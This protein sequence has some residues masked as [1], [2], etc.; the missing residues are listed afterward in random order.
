MPHLPVSIRSRLTLAVRHALFAGLL[1]GGPLL[2]A[3]PLT[4]ATASEQVR[5]YVIPAGPLDQALNLFASQAGILLSADARLTIGKRSPGLNGDYAV[6]EGL[7]NLLAGTGLR[8]HSTGGDYVL[9]VAMDG[10]DALELQSTTVR[11]VQLT[12][13]T[14]GTGSY[15]TGETSTATK[16]NLSLRE[17]PQ[18]ISVM[19]RQRIEDE[20]LT[21]IETLLDRTPGISVQNI[22][23]GRYD[24]SSRGYSID[25]FQ[26][27]GIPT[28]LDVVSQN[29]PQL[30]A[31]MVI[32]DRVEVLRGATGL[33]TGAGEPSGTINLIRKKPTHE[34]KGH[35]AAGVGNW[36]RYRTEFD[37]SGALIETGNLRGRFVGAYEEGGTH[38]DHY[39]QK[40]TVLY[41][42]LEADLSDQTRLTLGLDY[43]NTDPRGTSGSG[44]PLFYSNGE[45]TKFAPSKNAAARWSRNETDVYNTF[46]TLEH[47][48]ADDWALT[49][50]ANHM[51]GK[52]DFSGADASWGF[53]DKATGEGVMLYGGAGQARQK[54]TGAD[55]QIQGAFEMLGRRHDLVVGANWSEYENQHGPNNDD[56]EGRSINIYTWDN[57]TAATSAAE[58]LMDYDGWQKQYGSY[59]ALRLKPLDD[60]AVIIGAR[61]SNYKYQL[62]QIYSVPAF[63]QNNSITNMQ[64]S[65]VVTPYAGIVYDIN[66]THSVYASYTSIFKPQSERDRTGA[67]LAPREGENYEVGLKSEFFSGRLNSAIALYQ[68]RQDNLAEAEPGQTVPGTSPLQAAYRAVSGAKTE[69]I[70]IELAGELATGWQVSASYNYSSTEDAQGERIRTTFPRQMAK[71]WN[72]YRLP[73]EWNKLTIGGGIN[74]QDRIYYNATTWQLPGINLEG[75]QKSYAV[76]NL[77]ASYDFSDHLS[78]TLNLNN[79]FDREYLQGLDSTFHT[80]IYAP[81][82]NLMVSTKYNF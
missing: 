18:S 39:E 68:I 46:M 12:D 6:D 57:L 14:E 3:M 22:G 29:T 30:Q 41:G 1:T 24:I 56:I 65:G 82:R 5:N 48:L 49:L 61:V 78:T 60:V 43:Q 13:T 25:N 52:R 75:E 55:I 44:L 80:G 58:K 72:T 45:Q 69:G 20:N 74:W 63:T 15:T 81:T 8:A 31:D 27:D 76:V 11:G 16:L 19:T 2:L 67:T 51:Y 37:L 17:T 36:D 77:M 71:V 42:V 38:I 23:S 54:Q 34:F 47:R 70:D 59:A 21:S 53:P 62:S 79:L 10:G 33:L 35:V 50:S 26:L 73:G 66:D 64:E 28:A 4:H 32:Y 7:A 9:E 40:K